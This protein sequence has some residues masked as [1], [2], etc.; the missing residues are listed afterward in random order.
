[1]AKLSN[2]EIMDRLKDCAAEFVQLA[3]SNAGKQTLLNGDGKRH[4]LNHLN[5]LW[6]MLADGKSG[7]FEVRG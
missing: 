6:Q 2:E 7:E 1:M 4:G 5:E 3:R